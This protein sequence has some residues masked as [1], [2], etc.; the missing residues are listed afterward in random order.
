MDKG[1]YVG[2]MVSG[3][4]L[5]SEERP[6]TGP[7]HHI[8]R[9]RLGI[10]TYNTAVKHEQPQGHLSSRVNFA[11]LH[12]ISPCV[13]KAN[14][15]NWSDVAAHNVALPLTSSVAADIDQNQLNYCNAERLPLVG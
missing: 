10:I 12:Y 3:V 8:I 7:F 15:S 13:N 2:I 1:R 4:P 14:I 5:T 11:G 6:P 9:C